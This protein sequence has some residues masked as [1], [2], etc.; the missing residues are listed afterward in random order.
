MTPDCTTQDIFRRSAQFYDP[1]ALEDLR[2]CYLLARY[3]D[4]PPPPDL[5]RQ[6]KA[7]YN[8]TIQSAKTKEEASK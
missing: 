2:R 3:N 5:A 7:Y 1:Q 8:K 6:A 4:N